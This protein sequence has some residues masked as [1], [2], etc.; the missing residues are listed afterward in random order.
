MAGTNTLSAKK[1]DASGGAAEEK[2][3]M[4]RVLARNKSNQIPPGVCALAIMTK[5]PRAGAVKTRLQPPLTAEEAAALNIC[6]LRDTA[7]AIERACDIDQTDARGVGVYTPRGAEHAYEEILPREFELLPQHGHGFG[8]R[9]TNAAEDLLRA[10][11][12]S[13]CLID[14][15]SPTVTGNAFRAAV[16]ALQQKGDRIVLGPSEDGGYYLIGMKKLHRRLFEQI[17]WSTEQVLEQT[18]ARAREG[19]VEVHTLPVFFD[20]DDRAA[21]GRLCDELLGQSRQGAP[22]TS[23]FLQEIVDREGRARIWPE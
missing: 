7:A 18:I 14:S 10:G 22:A 3:G 16:E 15:D 5:A 6:F 2:R 20:I 4:H 8:E 23:Q 17:D 19:G 13:C 12:E 1:V 11:F 9:L 21:L